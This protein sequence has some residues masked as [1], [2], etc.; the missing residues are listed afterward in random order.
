MSQ[1]SLRASLRILLSSGEG[2]PR[3]EEL[4]RILE[5]AQEAQERGYFLPDE[6]DLLCE[7]FA[8][9]LGARYALWET[10]LTLRPLLDERRNPDWEL[11]LRAFAMAF[12]SAAML[13][14]SGSFLV[15]TARQ[16]PVVWTK[17]DAAESRFGIER[18]SF[19]R[20]YKSLS[21][22]RWMWR[23]YEAAQ[24]YD[25]HREEIRGILATEVEGASFTQIWDWLR[26]EEPWIEKSKRDY[27]KRRVRY[28]LFSFKRRHL[29]GYK[30]VMFHLFRLSG[31]AIAEM[32]QPLVKG[33]KS[34]QKTGEIVDEAG[35]G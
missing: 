35:D 34:L 22:A 12:C 5:H 19:T 16:W 31:S 2:L 23:Y 21:S 1:E 33:V 20:V 8:R 27:M 9:Y 7:V 30:K 6:D 24:F 4:E 29:S 11:R 17:L 25:L 28:K 18:K 15:E 10:V 3:R 14:R 32:R 13:V 26:E